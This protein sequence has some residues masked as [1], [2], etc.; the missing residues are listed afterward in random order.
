MTV[1]ATTDMHGNLFPIDYYNDDKPAN[2]EVFA[3]D[4][5]SGCVLRGYSSRIRPKTWGLRPVLQPID[6]GND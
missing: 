5:D 4:G 1:L 3:A 2:F 6:G